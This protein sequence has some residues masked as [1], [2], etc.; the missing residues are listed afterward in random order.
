[1]NEIPAEE[2]MERLERAQ[3]VIAEA[4]DKLERAFKELEARFEHQ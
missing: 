4:L 1:M 3:M 2:R